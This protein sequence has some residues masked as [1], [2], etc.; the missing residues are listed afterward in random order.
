MGIINVDFDAT[1]QILIIYSAFIKYLKKW[2]YNEAVFQLFIDFKKSYDSARREVLYNILVEFVI[3]KKLVRLIKMCLSEEYSRVRIGNDLSDML[4]VKNGLKKGG[5][6]SQLLL[7]FALYYA[8]R[9][10]QV[11]KDG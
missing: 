2:K 5:V 1:C 7:N 4:P 9:R 6:L 10:V 11:S 8:I 3:P